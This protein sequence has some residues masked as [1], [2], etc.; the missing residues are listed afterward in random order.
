M[1]RYSVILKKVNNVINEKNILKLSSASPFLVHLSSTF[2]DSVHLYMLQEF[3]PGGTLLSYIKENGNLSDDHARFYAA[4]I[5][6]GIKFLHSQRIVYRDLK[7]DNIIF[8]AE[9]HIKIADFGFAKRIAEEKTS[10]FCGTPSY[11][12]PEII[13]K[14][15][16]SYE[17][18][19]WAFGV[20]VFV[21]CSGCSPFQESVTTNTFS[22][23][24][25]SAIRWPPEPHL[26]FTNDSFDLIV[27][28]LEQEPED[29]P[30][31]DEICKHDWF[32]SLDFEAIE[33]HLVRPP[34]R[35]KAHTRKNS[36]IL[37][38]NVPFEYKQTLA[39][40]KLSEINAG[41]ELELS[42]EALEGDEDMSES[43]ENLFANF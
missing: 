28:L 33:H 42:R 21:L 13:Q 30:Y 3:L 6:L 27:W 25:N 9:G 39:I 41:I 23:I 43:F 4:E 34:N 20:I 19:W 38:P 35:V 40:H 26:F 10:T 8:D 31:A 24:L 37:D 22:R 5:Y 14:K 16:Y 15:P 12:A 18:D 36:I 2:Q 29:R 7:P 1:A 11:L 17:V 32:A